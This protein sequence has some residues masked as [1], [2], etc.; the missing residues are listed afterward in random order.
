MSFSSKSSNIIPYRC[1]HLCFILQSLY[2]KI[3][4]QLKTSKFTAKYDR[5]ERNLLIIKYFL[6]FRRI[7]VLSSSQDDISST[8]KEETWSSD[9]SDEDI[10]RRRELG[11]YSAREGSREMEYNDTLNS[12]MESLE[13]DQ[14]NRRGGKRPVL[15]QNNTKDQRN[16]SPEPQPGPS[17]LGD[18]E[19][20]SSQSRN[21]SPEPRSLG[22]VEPGRS[23]PGDIESGRNRLDDPEPRP[24]RPLNPEPARNRL[25][26]QTRINQKEPTSGKNKDG[27]RKGAKAKLIIIGKENAVPLRK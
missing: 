8:E 1:I 6:M 11:K 17:R 9:S 7:S 26:D 2:E 24:S 16:Y 14:R 22:D 15:K 12:S 23:S 20:G 27:S 21:P 10:L 19:P 5:E 3:I 4:T 25:K 18:I 13:E